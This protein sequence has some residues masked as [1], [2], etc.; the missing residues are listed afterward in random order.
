MKKLREQLLINTLLWGTILWLFGYVLG[1]IFYAF[2]PK[3]AIGWYI[4]PFA[5]L[6]TLWVLYKKIDRDS[7]GSYLWV[8]LVWLLIAVICD[9][10]F[11]VK[12]FQSAD[13]YK[14]DVYLYYALTL[15]LPVAVGWYKLNKPKKPKSI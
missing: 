11:L 7:L 6:A 1:I 8:G 4:L 14:F 13:Y 2:V 5:L 15:V 9:Y 12:L 10:L 3:S